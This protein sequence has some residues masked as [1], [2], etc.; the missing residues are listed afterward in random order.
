MPLSR[1]LH[2]NHLVK[3]TSSDLSPRALFS[4]V[5]SSIFSRKL[6]Q[7]SSK[8]SF[9]QLILVALLALFVAVSALPQYLGGWSW[10][11]PLK[12]PAANRHALQALPEKGLSLAGWVSDE[13][14]Q[15]EIGKDTWSVQQLS[16]AAAAQG[17]KLAPVFLLL[18]PQ[19]Y[20]DDQPEVEWLDIKG[21][22][23][24]ETDSSQPLSF[25]VNSAVSQTV[26]NSTERANKTENIRIR[27]DFFRAWNQDQT[28]AVLQWYAWPTG[29]SPSPA[30][31]FWADQKIQWSRRQRMPWVAVSLWLP[32]EPLGDISPHKAMAESL[33]KTIQTSLAQSVFVADDIAPSGSDESSGSKEVK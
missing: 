17:S 32:I 27:S 2:Q 9:I 25:E 30:Q 8:R 14:T 12:L 24:W 19:T 33:G 3:T 20:G 15:T 31:W 6:I 22:Q 5:S 10:D 28:Y 11:T 26:K 1:P 16:I 23:K 29:G 18:R 4:F 21:S 7:P 13:Q